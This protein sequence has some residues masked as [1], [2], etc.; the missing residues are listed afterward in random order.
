MVALFIV[1]L[2]G[3]VAIREIRIPQDG[4]EIPCLLYFSEMKRLLKCIQSFKSSGR[5]KWHKK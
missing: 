5:D 2:M 4:V 3:H 1:L